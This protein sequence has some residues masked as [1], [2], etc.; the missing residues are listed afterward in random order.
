MVN[1]LKKSGRWIGGIQS[2]ANTLIGKRLIGDINSQ[3]RSQVQNVP[4]YA[5][6]GVIKRT[7]LIRAHKG[8]IVINA[9]TAKALKSLMKR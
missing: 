5:V 3:M 8:E 9:K 4:S 7:G 6:G 1:R 2:G